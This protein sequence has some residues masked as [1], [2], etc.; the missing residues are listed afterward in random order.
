MNS[1]KSACSFAKSTP[2]PFY[3]LEKHVEPLL[4]RQICVELIVGAI[5]IL[6]TAKDS[7]DSIHAVRRLGRTDHYQ[8][9]KLRRCAQIAK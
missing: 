4:W 1:F 3:E 6:K 7:N 8:A 2:V 9:G 5:R